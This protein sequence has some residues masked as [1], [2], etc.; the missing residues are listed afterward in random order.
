MGILRR[1]METVDWQ[2]GRH[3]DDLLLS[4]QKEKYHRVS[5][6]AGADY[7]FAYDYLG[8]AFTVDLRPFAGKK[9]TAHWMNPV[10]GV[11]SYFA[12]LTGREQ[13]E[14]KPVARLTRDN[15]WVLVVRAWE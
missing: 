4:G 5:V 10:S 8:E 2:N 11:M 1:L 7:L 3:A 12:D 15:D 13:A 9:L 14:V 6:Y